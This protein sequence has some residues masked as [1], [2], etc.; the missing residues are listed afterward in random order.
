MLNLIDKLGDTNAHQAVRWFESFEQATDAIGW[1]DDARGRFLPLF[2]AGDVANTRDALADTDRHRYRAVKEAIVAYHARPA[3]ELDLRG[4]LASITM[5]PG[6]A[7]RAFGRRLLLL[8]ARIDPSMSDAAKVASFVN[9][10][11]ESLRDRLRTA[12]ATNPEG[13]M[14][15]PFSTVLDTASRMESTPN[16]VQPAAH[17]V[18]PAQVVA[19]AST[20][21]SDAA[22]GTGPAPS[23]S[24]VSSNVMD[25]TLGGYTTSAYPEASTSAPTSTP[26][27]DRLAR[28]I[29]AAIRA[30]QGTGA[31]PTTL[32]TCAWCGKRGHVAADCRTRLRE[33]RAT[34]TVTAAP[35]FTPRSRPPRPQ[36]PWQRGSGRPTARRPQH[37]GDG[38]VINNSA[39]TTPNA[40]NKVNGTTAAPKNF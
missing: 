18:S 14:K 31:A 40:T 20:S 27:E 35:S 37:H 9:G 2:L 11:P 30:A 10:L 4:Q 3:D 38:H 25:P 29:V 19:V 7:V 1:D 33:A 13:L 39:A 32:P 34:A 28:V 23:P 6:E 24:S 17:R 8:C 36:T 5:K 26:T 12:F 15:T 16:E 21:T 22:S